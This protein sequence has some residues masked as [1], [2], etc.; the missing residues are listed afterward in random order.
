MKKLL[1]LAL[2]LGGVATCIVSCTTTTNL[3]SW[4]D[5][6]NATYQYTKTTTDEALEKAMTQYDKV[7]H[8][9]KGTRGVVPPGMNAEYGYLL[10][11][12]GKVEEGLVLLREEIA[13]YP[14]SEVFISRIIKQLEK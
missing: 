6:E 12:A 14:E 8:K 1:L 4:Y 3:Y 5:S 7:L 2:C 13:L 11:K 9:Q 10:C